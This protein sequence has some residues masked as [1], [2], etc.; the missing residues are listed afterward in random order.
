VQQPKKLFIVGCYRSEALDASENLAR[1]LK[2]LR[3]RLT[4][5]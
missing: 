5:C 4:Y 1:T 3:E 2:Q